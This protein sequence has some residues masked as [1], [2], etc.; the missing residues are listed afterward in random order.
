MRELVPEYPRVQAHFERA[1]VAFT[2]E[3]DA[4]D[5]AV[6]LLGWDAPEGPDPERNAQLV[7]LLGQARDGYARAIDEIESALTKLQEAE[8]G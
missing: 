1:A 5:A 3:A 7:P 8:R 4:L 6:P 2:T